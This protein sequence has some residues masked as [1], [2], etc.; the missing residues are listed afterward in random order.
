MKDNSA[1]TYK[2]GFLFDKDN[3]W[4]HNKL[5]GLDWLQEFKSKYEFVETFKL[6]EAS[7][8]DV[9]FILG[10]TKILSN[11]FLS[12]NSLNLLVHESALPKGKGFS[13]V[14]WQVIDGI[15]E[16]PVCLIEAVNPV[17]SGDIFAMTKI[18]LNGDELLPEI[19]RSQA[20]ATK[21]LIVSFLKKYPAISK[22]PQAGEST[23]YR[24][25]ETEDDRLDPD[26]TI[27]E[28][29]NQLRVADNNLYPS[30]FEINGAKYV[31]YINKI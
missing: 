29:F 19:R 15:N 17:D 7:G 24:K 6:E 1:V 20:I 21:N 2:V 27:R 16:I 18:K 4:I 8:F 30:Y 31:I 11:H 28:Q 5:S 3:S 22:Y 13:P 25:R 23:F 10:Y 26:K 12:L 9:L 14:Q